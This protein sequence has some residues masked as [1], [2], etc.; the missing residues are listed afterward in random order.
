MSSNPTGES[1]DAS[2]QI[3]ARCRVVRCPRL[4]AMQF[5]VPDVIEYDVRVYHLVVVLS[6]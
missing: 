6:S 4:T 1:K 2:P 5:N 3:Q